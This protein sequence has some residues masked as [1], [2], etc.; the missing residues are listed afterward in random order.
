[1]EGLHFKDNPER[2]G[3]LTTDP[4]GQLDILGHDGHPLGVDGTEVGV[5]EETHQVSLASLLKSHHSRALEPQISFEVLG[6]LANM[7]LERQLADEQ[8]C[9]LL[10]PP[11]LPQSNC[12]RSITVGLLDTPSGG[13]RLPGSLGGKLLPRSFASSGLASSLLGP[14]HGWIG[15]DWLLVN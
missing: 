10:I 2:L 8:L 15:L 7:T 9:G 3:P 14:C 5:L 12:A 6:N 1:M 11:D 13:G 4:P